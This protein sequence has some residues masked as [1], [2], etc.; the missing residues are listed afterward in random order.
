MEMNGWAYLGLGVD[1]ADPVL[2]DG[3]QQDLREVGLRGLLL[4]E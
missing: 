4:A 1:E 3:N 2:V